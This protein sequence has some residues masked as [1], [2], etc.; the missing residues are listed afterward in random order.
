MVFHIHGPEG[1]KSL[2]VGLL[3]GRSFQYHQPQPFDRLRPFSH[4]FLLLHRT[5]PGVVAFHQV[6]DP[7]HG[8]GRVA[9]PHQR[10][11]GW[12]RLDAINNGFAT[13][14]ERLSRSAGAQCT[15][16]FFL[17]NRQFHPAFANSRPDWF[18]VDDMVDVVD[19]DQMIFEETVTD[20]Q[21]AGW[22]DGCSHLSKCNIVKDN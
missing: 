3:S 15:H 9:R 21:L 16:R 2:A 20:P 19:D 8:E 17:Q 1:D 7:C 11:G 14:L 4:R 12:R 10:L 18:D 13:A 6:I 5:A 22:T